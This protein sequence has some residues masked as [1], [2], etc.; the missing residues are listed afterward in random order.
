MASKNGDYAPMLPDLKL[1][2]YILFL[3]HF[4]KGK[5][6]VENVIPYYDA[7]IKPTVQLGRHYF[8]SN[9]CIPFKEF[10]NN[11]IKHNDVSGDQRRFGFKI[12]EFGI[13]NK[14]KRTILRNC[15]DPKIG[16]Y[17]LDCAKEKIIQAQLQTVP[18]I[19]S[20]VKP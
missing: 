12:E 1:Y 5:W 19:L 3:K 11:E 13:D 10:V 6:C 17:I 7:P 4:F 18:F 2:S 9:M 16:L 8:W 20:D 15:V 14:Q